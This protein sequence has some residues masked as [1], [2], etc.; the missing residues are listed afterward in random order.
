MNTLVS[1][2]KKEREK[3]KYQPFVRHFPLL[4][5]DSADSCQA[6]DFRIFEARK[7]GDNLFCARR[8]A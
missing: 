4:L 8:A 6:L 5:D 2:E 3:K 1:K 7:L